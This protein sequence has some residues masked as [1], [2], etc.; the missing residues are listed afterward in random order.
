M[1][2]CREC[3]KE[4][5]EDWK[6]CPYCE[7]HIDYLNQRVNISDA[8]VMGNISTT[9]H[10]DPEAIGQ[11]FKMAMKEIEEEEEQRLLS[12]AEEAKRQRQETEAAKKQVEV[13]RQRQAQESNMA[14]AAFGIEGI[15]VDGV[16]VYTMPQSFS[17][18]AELL[19]NAE[20]FWLLELDDG[21][22]EYIQSGCGDG[23]PS[24]AGPPV[25]VEYQKGPWLG[26]ATKKT[27][28]QTHS[29]AIEFIRENYLQSP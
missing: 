17:Q 26:D 23:W 9:H 6:V 16:P 4:I 28:H 20:E 10:N 24:S 14:M 13:E 27:T 22:N 11:G 25:D 5:Q 1:P 15:K 21:A 7:D 2:F 18:L 29:E 3:G 19:L 8:V 12:E